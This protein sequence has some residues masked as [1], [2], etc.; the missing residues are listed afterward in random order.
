[1]LQY[2][3][4][5]SILIDAVRPLAGD[6]VSER[7]GYNKRKI[8]PRNHK[9]EGRA[10]INFAPI[11]KIEKQYI[12][13]KNLTSDGRAIKSGFEVSAPPSFICSLC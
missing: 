10:K 3:K 4:C 2:S 5:K 13:R 1:M 12:E 8:L 6:S 11:L 9:D 7:G